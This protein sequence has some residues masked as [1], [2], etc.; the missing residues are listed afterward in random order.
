MR[1]T[2]HATDKGKA[3]EPALSEIVRPVPRDVARLRAT[4]LIL[5]RISSREGRI[6][7]T[8]SLAAGGAQ[9]LASSAPAALER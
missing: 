1:S 2:N 4:A 5:E 7:Q 8:L 3:R 6:S 9:P